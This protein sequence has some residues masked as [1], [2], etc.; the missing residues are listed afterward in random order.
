MN[1]MLLIFWVTLIL[2]ILLETDAV[3]KWAEALRLK[4]FKYEEF[5]ERQ[6]LFGD[7]KYHQFL[8]GNYNNIFVALFACSECLCIWLNIIGFI[9]FAP[10]LGGWAMF[11]PTAMTSMIFIAL[12]KLIL[13]RLYE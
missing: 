5:K 7:I 6:K 4:F 9:I 13:K 11:A 10:E 8:A 1:N 2:Y 12:F 3:V